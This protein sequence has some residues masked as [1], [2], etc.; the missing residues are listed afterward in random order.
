MCVLLCNGVADVNARNCVLSAFFVI[1]THSG[2]MQNWWCL[3]CVLHVV[4]AE[5]RTRRQKLCEQKLTMKK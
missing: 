5:Q 3:W 4:G 2:T 1:H